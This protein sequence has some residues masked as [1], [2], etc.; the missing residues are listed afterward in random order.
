MGG[1]SGVIKR[2][3]SLMVESGRFYR[4]PF[5]NLAVNLTK[6]SNDRIKVTARSLKAEKRKGKMQVVKE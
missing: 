5:K 6:I 1:G 4:D 3:Q 2:S